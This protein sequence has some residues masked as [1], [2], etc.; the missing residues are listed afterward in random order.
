MQTKK[1]SI[2]DAHVN[3]GGLEQA[4]IYIHGKWGRP[5]NLAFYRD[6]IFHYGDQLPRFFLLLEG[7]RILGCG[8]LIANDFVSRHDLWPWYACHY[9]EPDHRGRGLGKLLLDHAVR[10]AGELGFDSVYLSTDHQGYYEKYGWKRIEDGYEP[11]G[12]PTRIYRFNLSRGL[13]PEGY[14]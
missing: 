6:A 1:F 9:I 12:A 8:A 10:L 5:G 3:P 7:E 2:V 4:I 13:F 11:S 14:A